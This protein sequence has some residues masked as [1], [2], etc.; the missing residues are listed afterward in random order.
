MSIL[1]SEKQTCSAQETIDRVIGDCV[2]NELAS[3]LSRAGKLT[4]EFVKEIS[5]VDYKVGISDQLYKELQE[6]KAVTDPI[7]VIKKT[8]KVSDKP[9]KVS[10]KPRKVREAKKPLTSCIFF[11]MEKRVEVKQEFPDMKEKQTRKRSFGTS[12]GVK[13]PVSSYMFFS[14]DKLPEIKNAN[15]QITLKELYSELG[16]LWR[17]VFNTEKIREKW[18]KLAEVDRKRYY[19]E[20]EKASSEDE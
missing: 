15:P 14:K 20:K 10:D 17:E 9:R 7:K 16:R 12:K 1:I 2:R 5:T 11:S 19:D 3:M 18:V 13:R 4:P 6:S 8:R